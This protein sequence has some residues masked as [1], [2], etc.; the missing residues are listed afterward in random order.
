MI[1][2]DGVDKTWNYTKSENACY[3]VARR[4]CQNDHDDESGENA[5][6]LDHN[7]WL[8]CEICRHSKTRKNRRELSE[9]DTA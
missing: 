3:Y 2:I 1:V 4:T 7:Y 6:E 5:A 9:E 8:M